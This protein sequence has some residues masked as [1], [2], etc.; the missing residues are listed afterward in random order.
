MQ[1]RSVDL[2]MLVALDVLLEERNV[3]RAAERLLIGQ[4]AMSSTL[5]RLR[6]LFDDPLLVREGRVFT[7]TT[8]ADSLVAPLQEALAILESMLS[9]GDT[10]D[11]AVDARTFSIIAS[12]YVALVILRPLLEKLHTIAP[13]VQLNVKPIEPD[14]LEQ[15]AR[16][17]ADLL[18]TPRELLPTRVNL[19]VEPLFTDRYVFVMDAANAA[20]GRTLDAE[21]FHSLPYLVTTQGGMPTMVESRLDDLGVRRN[22]EMVAQSFVMAPFLLPGTQMI[23]VMQERLTRLIMDGPSFSV[24]PSPFDLGTI[25]EAM[26]WAPRQTND[27]GLEWLRGQLRELAG[28]I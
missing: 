5:A 9:G 28:T 25:T 11:P 13:N 24:H 17:Q 8:F 21:L 23:T 26:V 16:R 22:V 4:S 19:I 1:L 3:S 10:F 6:A 2:N 27:A 15:V 18:I 20:A 7:T 14:F 12:D